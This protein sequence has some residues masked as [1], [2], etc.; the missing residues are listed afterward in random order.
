VTRNVD[1]DADV[2]RY[3]SPSPSPPHRSGDGSFPPLIKEH[4]QVAVTSGAACGE[5]ARILFIDHT[6]KMSGGEIAL[7]NLVAGMDRS[8]FEVRVL[9]FSDGW[10]VEALKAAGVD[11]EVMPLSAKVL[12]TRKDSLGV[13]TLT[14]I[15]TAFRAGYFVLRTAR[16]I[17]KYRPALVHT[18]SLKSDII[19]GMAGR[20]A[21]VKVIWHIRDRISSDYLPSP[22]VLVFRRLCRVIPTCVVA[23]SLSTLQTVKLP[24][25]RRGELIYSGAS[26]SGGRVVYDGTPEAISEALLPAFPTIGLVGRITRWK[27]QHIFIRAAAEVLKI[28][29]NAR[30]KIIGAPL[31]AEKA[32]EEELRALVKTLG[33]EHAV[34]F[35]GFRTD[36]SQIVSELQI[37]AHASITGEPFG[38][39]VIEGMIAKKPVVATRGGGIPEIVVDGVTGILVPMGDREAM[40]AGISRLLGDP[41]L[42][43]RMGRAGHARVLER[44]TIQHTINRVEQLYS[45]LLHPAFDR[46]RA[47]TPTNLLLIR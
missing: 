11:V 25:K 22:V 30:F 14:K 43:A 24:L 4:H 39:V 47:A 8:R 28:F 7:L 40:A 45:D 32:Y 1:S 27:G 12:E 6:A 16:Y 10:M 21:G 42:A 23:N 9:V 44:F 18:N 5:R 2:A 17:R 38:Q 36:I 31:F 34:E 15:A 37:L 19:G 20:L 35:T 26:L 3:T 33:V 46:R 29:P 41:A 13:G